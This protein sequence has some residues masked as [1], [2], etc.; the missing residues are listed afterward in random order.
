MT[1]NEGDGVT[2]P[3]TGPA[4]DSGHISPSGVILD[5][6]MEKFV[7]LYIEEMEL[8]DGDSE[9]DDDTRV[10]NTTL[11]YN[12]TNAECKKHKQKIKKWDKKAWKALMIILHSLHPTLLPF[13]G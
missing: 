7:V 13:I 1:I 11:I 3:E 9:D 12:R 6:M 10:L 2:T 5:M 8:K 4:G